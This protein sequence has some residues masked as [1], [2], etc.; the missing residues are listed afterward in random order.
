MTKPCTPT[1]PSPSLAQLA[2]SI[3]LTALSLSTSFSAAQAASAHGDGAQSESSL[4]GSGSTS[5]AP[6]SSSEAGEQSRRDELTGRQNRMMLST[7]QAY[8][9]Q[10][11]F[12]EKMTGTQRTQPQF[13]ALKEGFQEL[14]GDELLMLSVVS[15]VPPDEADWTTKF[16]REWRLRTSSGMGRL[17]DESAMKLLRPISMAVGRLSPEQCTR[18]KDPETKRSGTNSFTAILL[19]VMSDSEVRQLYSAFHDA[20]L[21]DMNKRPFR[22]LP[23]KTELAEVFSAIDRINAQLQ[24]GAKDATPCT[25]S[26]RLMDAVDKAPQPT[27]SQAITYLLTVTGFYVQKGH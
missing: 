2:A 15:A 26:R 20:L 13:K 25:S 10:D 22:V 9:Q 17:S 8:A 27:R 21:A 3:L 6:D 23:N 4:S 11:E 16:D 5:S 1:R 14:Y 12:I 7:L 19:P 24:G 18:Y